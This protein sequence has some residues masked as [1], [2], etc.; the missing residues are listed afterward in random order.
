MPTYTLQHDAPWAAAQRQPIAS[1][2]SPG[3]SRS[4]KSPA[5]P[6]YSQEQDGLFDDDGSQTPAFQ[7]QQQQARL[8]V[9]QQVRSML[10][11]RRPA[12][13]PRWDP[14]SGELTSNPNGKAGQVQPSTYKPPVQYEARRRSLDRRPTGRS[15]RSYRQS[16]S[17]SPVS[18]LRPEEM[19]YDYRP[20][21]DMSPYDIRPKSPVSPMSMA[22]RH[23]R[24]ESTAT[25]GTIP[26]MMLQSYVPEPPPVPISHVPISQVPKRKPV[27]RN[28]PSPAAQPELPPLPKQESEPEPEPLRRESMPDTL[29]IHHEP[30]LTLQQLPSSRFSWTTYAASTRSPSNR[31]KEFQNTPQPFSPVVEEAGP[32]SRFSWSTIATTATNQPN[33]M[34]SPPPSPPPPV[35]DKYKAPPIQSILSRQRPVP[36]TEPSEPA[37]KPAGRSL[38][39]RVS[40]QNTV[41]VGRPTEITTLKPPPAPASKLR[42]VTEPPRPV[43]SAANQPTPTALRVTTDPRP[44][45]AG[46]GAAGAPSGAG[47]KALPPPPTPTSTS[48]LS[49]LDT[50][51][52]LEQDKIHQRKNIERIVASLAQLESASPLDVSFGQVRDAKRKLEE[53]RITLDEI[54]LEER[55]IGIAISRARRKEGE[56]EGLWVRRVMGNKG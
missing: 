27:S 30:E 35:P 33:R 52:R 14:Y 12:V 9:F 49:H 29:E 39:P 32:N 19:E 34:D 11:Q 42:V 25:S 41:Q 53:M 50:L 36:R 56:E 44:R 55:E 17:V 3:F 5:H 45:T 7:T 21:M 24:F 18:M 10:Q 40:S 51:L 54:K 38:P 23:S 26:V 43:T 16:R 37:E 48:P 20:S 47:D 22:T 28:T 2:T 31:Q 1:P 4:Q 13:P 8:P 6:F 46:P 15:G